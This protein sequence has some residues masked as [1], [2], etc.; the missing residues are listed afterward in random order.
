MREEIDYLCYHRKHFIL[1]NE[2]LS[3]KLSMIKLNRFQILF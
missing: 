1:I 3:K 2:S